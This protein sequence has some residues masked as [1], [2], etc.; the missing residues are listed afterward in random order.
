VLC[1]SCI[2]AVG[3]V[4]SQQLHVVHV[5]PDGRGRSYLE[6]PKNRPGGSKG[7]ELRYKY[8]LTILLPPTKRSP[9]KPNLIIRLE[10][11]SDESILSHPHS[12]SFHHESLFVSSFATTPHRHGLAINIPVRIRRYRTCRRGDR[13]ARLRSGVP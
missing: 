13:F 6:L 8:I 3:G 12:L 2:Y 1:I 9:T 10:R 4:K 7:M 5:R 11:P